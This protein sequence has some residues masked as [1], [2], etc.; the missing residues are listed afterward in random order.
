MTVRRPIHG[1]PPMTGFARRREPTILRHRG[2]VVLRAASRPNFLKDAR[3][4]ADIVARRQ[5]WLVSHNRT[6]CACG[7]IAA[8]ALGK[9]DHRMHSTFV[10][11][12]LQVVKR[13]ARA[14]ICCAA[15]EA[16]G[17]F[18]WRRLG[19]PPFNQQAPDDPQLVHAADQ[20]T[21]ALSENF[22][23]HLALHRNL[24]LATQPICASSSPTNDQQH[25]ARAL[26]RRPTCSEPC[27][28]QGGVSGR[29]SEA[30]RLSAVSPQPA[31]N[32]RRLGFGGRPNR[33]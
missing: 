20:A 1:L 11:S 26:P 5:D 3:V 15:T 29:D 27:H 30:C 33:K 6:S 9:L 22:A 24:S 18:V 10:P 8:I 23:W 16:T 19:R 13:S 21:N 28:T 32:I 14:A 17:I 25:R 31:S 7:V 4:A 12:G 2:K